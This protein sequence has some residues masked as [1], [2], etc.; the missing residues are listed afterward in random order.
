M[1]K[2]LDFIDSLRGFAILGVILV[3]T[4]QIIPDLP[5]VFYMM[6]GEGARGVQLFYIASAF[7]L[8]YSLKC[9]HRIENNAIT[10][11]FIRR[12]FRIAPLYYLALLFYLWRGDQE[13]SIMNILV[14]AAFLNGWSPYW[15]N[16]IIPGGW[17]VPIE[18][19]F[20]LLVPLLFKKLNNIKQA[21]Y[22]LLLSLCLYQVLRQLLWFQPLVDNVQVWKDFLYFYL[23]SQLPVFG[24]GIVLFFLVT[25]RFAQSGD[26]K[27][28]RNIAAKM[29]IVAGI[30]VST[31]AI[32]YLSTT[33]NNYF[34]RHL[35]SSVGFLAFAFGLGLYP[36]R[37]FV[38]RYTVFLG[39]ISFSA[40]L[41]HNAVMRIVQENLQA[42]VHRFLSNYFVSRVV[43]MIVVYGIVLVLTVAVSSITYH[44]V[45]KN[46]ISL[47]QK[48]IVFLTQPIFASEKMTEE[49]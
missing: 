8:F 30:I 33:I 2:R 25:D 42:P 37:F 1:G 21:G 44:F 39:K 9:N 27:N 36:S 17:S 7:A 4:S 10:N 38:N 24:M 11:Y 41:S 13:Y 47:G 29:M 22:F 20:Y 28:K 49:A 45:E 18:M 16:S 46:G 32:V 12:F 14:N 19:T 35:W 31:G 15:I 48:I 3:H 34:P 23:P 26:E 43:E 6:V 5:G 40:Y